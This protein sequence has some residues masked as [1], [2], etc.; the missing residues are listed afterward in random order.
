MTQQPRLKKTNFF[1]GPPD[2][3]K[4][5]ENHSAGG[6]GS[7]HRTKVLPKPR[8]GFNRRGLVATVMLGGFRRS[9]QPPPPS[10]MEPITGAEISRG[11][12]RPAA[13]LAHQITGQL[14]SQCV[15]EPCTNLEACGAPDVLVLYLS[16]KLD[17]VSLIGL[18]VLAMQKIISDEHFPEMERRGGGGSPG[19]CSG[20]RTL[21]RGGGGKYATFCYLWLPCRSSWQEGQSEREPGPLSY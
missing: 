1:F 6:Q 7:L 10:P 2:N 19:S 17:C 15:H 14:L 3:K 18:P 9:V 4:Q 13:C 12:I 16:V 5:Q 21:E 20:A 11:S 8:G